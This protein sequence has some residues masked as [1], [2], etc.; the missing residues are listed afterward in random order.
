MISF[1]SGEQLW[2][3]RIMELGDPVRTDPVFYVAGNDWVMEHTVV[4]TAGVNNMKVGD[5]TVKASNPFKEYSYR[6]YV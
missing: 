3:E 6:I 5:Y 4:D 2:V 1:L